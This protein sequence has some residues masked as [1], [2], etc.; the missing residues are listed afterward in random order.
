MKARL[1]L[2]VRVSSRL[3]MILSMLHCPYRLA[4][5]THIHPVFHI[6]LLKQ[7]VGSHPFSVIIPPSIT[8]DMEQL[9][10]PGAIIA[11]RPTLVIDQVS[12]EVMYCCLDLPTYEDS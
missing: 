2:G 10:Q 11:V 4:T 6:S 12:P 8:L 7:A 3:W 1:I 5:Y 9:V